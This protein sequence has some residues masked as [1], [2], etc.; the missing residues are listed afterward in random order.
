MTDSNPNAAPLPDRTGAGTRA[1]RLIAQRAELF[2]DADGTTYMHEKGSAGSTVRVLGKEGADVISKVLWG[3]SSK[4]LTSQQMQLA[5]STLHG[6]ALNGE[7]RKVHLRIAEYHDAIYVDLGDGSAGFVRISEEGWELR[8]NAPVTFYRP[9]AQRSL[10]TPAKGGSIDALRSFINVASDD[11]FKLFVGCLLACYRPGVPCPIV[12][13]NGE[14]GS[15]KSTATR[16]FKALTDPNKAPLRTLPKTEDDLV[17]TAQNSHVLAYDNLSSLSTEMLDSLCRLC[18]GGG[19]AKR[20]LYSDGDEFVLDVRRPIVCNGINDFG[21]RGDFAERSVMLQLAS[22]TSARRD[23]QEFWAAFA[24][25]APKI[26]GSLFDLLA[27]AL[28]NLPRVK[29]PDPPRMADYA[30]LL[31]AAAPALGT[32]GPELVAAFRANQDRVADQLE[33]DP[34]AQL[35]ERVITKHGR[36]E[37]GARVV[38]G[39]PAVVFR[40]LKQ[41]HDRGEAIHKFPR[42]SNNCSRWLRRMAPQLR[43]I[44]FIVEIDG[45]NGAGNDKRKTWILGYTLENADRV[46]RVDMG[47]ILAIAD[48]A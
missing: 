40:K 37:D 45:R 18:T 4:G 14:Q 46:D 28:R 19:V 47:S 33:D 31:W 44:G 27:S 32:T 7:Q 8:D 24:K 16:I 30:R 9:G 12:N 3:T 6:A 22:I 42:A 21:E 17:V 38:V 13:F 35:L 43:R 26:L 23:E 15:A 5:Q 39:E 41:E 36:D 48:P 34:F 25:A 11:D 1:A 2:H 10:P 29:V 20:K